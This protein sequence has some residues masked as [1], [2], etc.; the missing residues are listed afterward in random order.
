MLCSTEYR[1]ETNTKHPVRRIALFALTVLTLASAL[2]IAAFADT[3]TELATVAATPTTKPTATPNSA[4][5]LAASAKVTLRSDVGGK[6]YQPSAYPEPSTKKAEYFEW[7]M[8]LEYPYTAIAM[9]HSYKTCGC[10]EAYSGVLVGPHTLLTSAQT[11]VCPIH[12]GTAEHIDIWFGRDAD[13]NW[14]YYTDQYTAYAMT[15]FVGRHGDHYYTN[16]NNWRVIELKEDV[17]K[18]LGWFGLC[19]REDEGLYTHQ[20]YIAGYV[21]GSFGTEIVTMGD[22]VP[23]EQAFSANTYEGYSDLIG[24]PIFDVRCNVVGIRNGKA[25]ARVT[26]RMLDLIRPSVPSWYSKTASKPSVDI[27]ADVLSGANLQGS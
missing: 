15:D 20:A 21:N 14:L 27:P 10:A 9:I 18:E 7:K 6:Q 11:C 16:E 17:G 8:P 4:S 3:R 2:P 5:S 25:C 23:Q 22:T 12:G 24:A 26:D 13:T 19:T 1:E